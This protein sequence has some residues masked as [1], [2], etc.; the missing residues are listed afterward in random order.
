MDF[1]DPSYKSEENCVDEIDDYEEEGSEEEESDLSSAESDSEVSVPLES[2]NDIKFEDEPLMMK[3]TQENYGL[4]SETHIH[5]LYESF[6]SSTQNSE[7]MN[8]KR[9]RRWASMAMWGDESITAMS[10]CAQACTRSRAVMHTRACSRTGVCA[11][12]RAH[13]QVCAL[14]S[15]CHIVHRRLGV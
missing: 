6:E 12:V 4:E 1:T 15:V 10:V 5:A 11:C 9:K 13:A 2:D 8:E 14:G 7:K 3:E